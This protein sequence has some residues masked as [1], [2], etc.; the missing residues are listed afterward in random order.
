MLRLLARGEVVRSWR[1]D[2]YW[3]DIGRHDDH[4]LAVREFERNRRRFVPDDHSVNGR[5]G[6]GLDTV[7]A[8]ARARR[9]HA[10]VTGGAGFIGSHLVDALLAAGSTVAV[11]DNLTSGKR[12]NVDTRARL[13]AVDVSDSGALERVFAR[14]RP[15]LVFHLAGQLEPRGS[16]AEPALDVDV[17]VR[18]TAAVLEAA[19]VY[20]VERVV[21]ASSGSVVYGDADVV[22]TPE[23]APAEPLSP[24]GASKAAAEADCS[25]YARRHDLSTVSLRLGNVYGPRQDPR[26]EAGVIARFCGAALGDGIASVSGDGLQTR[27]FIH[28]SDVVAAFL[29]AGS[30]R[31]IGAFNVGTGVATTILELAEALALRPVHEP[32]RLGEVRRTC[33]DSGAA[34]TQLGWSAHMSLA[35]GLSSTLE[36]TRERLEAPEALGPLMAGPALRLR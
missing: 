9:P 29:A 25:L 24:Y 6:P 19:R 33:L 14:E 10:L 11:V 2:A 16:V 27:D 23:S 7:T 30:A 8:G 36:W 18:G 3:L 5:D 1:P 34:R 4:E 32:A 26:G 21:H 20:G 35:D 28:V 31:A 17:N 12:D 22:P 13:H 15:H